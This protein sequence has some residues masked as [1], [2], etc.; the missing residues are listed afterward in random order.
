MTLHDLEGMQSLKCHDIC[1]QLRSCLLGLDSLLNHHCIAI[2]FN[3][4]VELSG[5]IIGK[6]SA[7]EKLP[8]RNTGGLG[9]EEDAVPDTDPSDVSSGTLYSI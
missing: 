1:L 3:G 2:K 7:P 5:P 9:S 8:Y 4:K 6:M